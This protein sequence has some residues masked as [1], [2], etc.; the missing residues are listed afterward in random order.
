MEQ[1]TYLF[2]NCK[3]LTKLYVNL[4][5]TINLNTKYFGVP[6]IKTF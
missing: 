3:Y 2:K 5:I 4:K 6:N 1:N